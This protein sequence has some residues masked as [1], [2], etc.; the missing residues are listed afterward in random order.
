MDNGKTYVI[1][2]DWDAEIRDLLVLNT[3]TPKGS[4]HL[5]LPH[6]CVR[7]DTFSIC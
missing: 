3:E 7:N 5:I 2:G 4:V 6:N 1:T